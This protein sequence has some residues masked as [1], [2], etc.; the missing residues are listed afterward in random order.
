MKKDIHVLKFLLFNL[1]KSFKYVLTTQKI[2]NDYKL[3]SGVEIRVKNFC[4]PDQN[5]VTLSLW[6]IVPDEEFTS[7]R[8][9]YYMGSFGAIFFTSIDSSKEM[10]RIK[11]IITDIHK[12]SMDDFYLIFDTENHSEFLNSLVN[13]V[14]SV[15]KDVDIT[16]YYIDQNL[17]EIIEKGIIKTL[18]NLMVDI[19]R[20]RLKIRI[21][22]ID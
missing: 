12:K 17:Y 5:V 14:N 10:H 16:I 11:Q 6:D 7:I 13:E 8:K 9:I 15:I 4:L 20:R 19:K 1:S 21:E 22:N 2:L 18:H 3:T